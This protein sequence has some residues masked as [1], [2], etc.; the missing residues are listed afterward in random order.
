MG[1]SDQWGNI[2]TG[3]ELIRRKLGGDAFALTCPLITKSDGGKFGKSESGN[4]WLDP[5]KT[6]PYKFYQ[7]WL[8]T[9]DADASE[10][11]KKFTLLS[12]EEVETFQEQHNEAPHLRILQR[13]LA[14]DI[15]IRVHSAEDL[16]A[17]IEAS[18]ILFGKGTTETLMKLSEETL[19]SVFEGVPQCEIAKSEVLKTINVVDFLSEMTRIFSSKG[20][21]RRMLKEGGVAINKGKVDESSSVNSDSLLNGKYILVQKG[22]KNYFLVKTT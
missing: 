6:S 5:Q 4:V 8:N 22:K 15:T 17:A 1:G 19:L 3:T 18:E 14:E 7:F 10:Y 16:N 13:A 11:I 20:E 9:S 21:A 2:V 12:K